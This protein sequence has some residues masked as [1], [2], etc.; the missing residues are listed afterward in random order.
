MNEEM[1]S[2]NEELASSNE[3]L[4]AT[5]E[6]L[7]RMQAEIQIE[8]QNRQI[9]LEKLEASEQNIRNMVLQAPMGMC[10]LQGDPLYVTEVNDAFLKIIGKTQEEI[11]LRLTGRF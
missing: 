1:S 8:T 2:V 10:I 6:K 7:V 5:N 4:T 3:E 11:K 9:A